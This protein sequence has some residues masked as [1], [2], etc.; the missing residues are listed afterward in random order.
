[1]D[2]I[3][4][5]LTAN[6]GFV[7]PMLAMVF[8]TMI[9]WFYMYYRRLSYVFANKIKPQALD[10]PTKR[11]ILPDDVNNVAYNFV[12]LFEMPI[13]FYVLCGLFIMTGSGDQLSLAF[14]WGFVATRAVHSFIQCTYN[15]VIHRFYIYSL[16][17]FLLFALV[18]KAATLML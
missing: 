17:S 10:N 5:S 14:A 18:I 2:N 3:L 8:L 16:G 11:A 15:K 13:L 7:A 1:M 12:N 4:S 9:V 6:N